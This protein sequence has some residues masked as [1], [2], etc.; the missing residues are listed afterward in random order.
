MQSCAPGDYTW[1]NNVTQTQ[2][3]FMLADPTRYQDSKH[4]TYAQ[5]DANNFQGYVCPHKTF[6]MV[7]LTQSLYRLTKEQVAG[8]EVVNSDL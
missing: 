4:V 1:H 2:F 5:L 3:M 7:L 6:I 8:K